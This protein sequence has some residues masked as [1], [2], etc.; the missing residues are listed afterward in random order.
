MALG[1]VLTSAKLRGPEANALAGRLHY[2]ATNTFGF[3]AKPALKVLNRHA[4]RVPSHEQI[5]AEVKLA[6][7][8]L[9]RFLNE[10]KPRAITKKDI[11]APIIVLTDGAGE[12]D[13][14]TCG[15]VVFDV[16]SGACYV[17]GGHCPAD[18][19]AAWRATSGEQVICQAELYPM[20]LAR[21]NF[22]ELM[23]DRRVLFFVDNNA[24]RDSSIRGDSDS[25]ASRTLLTIFHA[26]DISEPARHW[27]S[28]VPT[29]INIADDP[30]R[31][32]VRETATLLG[33]QIIEVPV[34]APEFVAAILSSR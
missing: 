20:V 32:K 27:F 16:S 29:H 33:A 2:A 34:L 1:R 18:I 8:F 14:V 19:V 24:A 5:T 30:S 28:R 15:A 12:G 13:Q 6:L 22:K 17:F 10:A 21:H 11:L 7:Q 9:V 31:L 4:A 3:A 23:R 25:L 26:A